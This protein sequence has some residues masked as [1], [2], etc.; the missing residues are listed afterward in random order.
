MALARPILNAHANSS[1]VSR[2]K[3]HSMTRAPRRMPRRAV[4]TAG[5]KRTRSS[6]RVRVVVGAADT[7]NT[8]PAQECM[9]TRTSNSCA[10]NSCTSVTSSDAQLDVCLDTLVE[11]LQ[12]C[13]CIESRL[14]ILILP[15]QH[16]V[17]RSCLS[18]TVSLAQISVDTSQLAR[19]RRVENLGS[20]DD[21]R[22]CVDVST[23]LACPQCKDER[24]YWVYGFQNV[25][26]A[27][28]SQT[29]GTIALLFRER[30]ARLERQ[31]ARLVEGEDEQD[32]LDALLARSFAFLPVSNNSESAGVP[33]VHYRCAHRRCANVST[34]SECMARH[35]QRCGRYSLACPFAKERSRAASE[36][37][38]GQRAS[39]SV[40]S[41]ASLSAGA[42]AVD[43]VIECPAGKLW[44]LGHD[45]R[46]QKSSEN[47]REMNVVAQYAAALQ[48]HVSTGLCVH[49]MTLSCN[50]CTQDVRISD[51]VQHAQT[52]QPSLVDTIAAQPRHEQRQHDSGSSQASTIATAQFMLAQLQHVESAAFRVNGFCQGEMYTKPGGDARHYSPSASEEEQEWDWD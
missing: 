38:A 49:P 31:R 3:K 16:R 4:S 1:I 52:H 48:A 46:G 21:V 40:S 2:K 35:W 5:S 7:T 39:S 19:V 36:Q 8:L 47:E 32:G 45:P 29:I 22:K 30:R 44:L 9:A 41:S 43:G 10:P 18:D 25:L 51:F 50:Y 42:G 11:Q 24:L 12:C 27:L 33:S 28:P 6:A 20:L 14:D 23:M 34:S 37:A 26:S 15:C 13:V 17:C